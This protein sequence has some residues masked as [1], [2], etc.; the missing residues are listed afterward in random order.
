M[1]DTLAISPVPVV[2]P[3]DDPRQGP[4]M[5]G[6]GIN[7]RYIYA[8]VRANL[9]LVLT[10]IGVS[11]ALSVL[12]SFLQKPV[13]TALTT[14]QINNSSNTRV[15]KKS[16]DDDQG[17]DAS[18]ASDTDLYLRTQVDILK[19]RSLAI[20]VA[21][22]M[23]LGENAAFFKA[24]GVSMPGP[25]STPAMREASA[26]ALL[27]KHIDVQLPHDTRIAQVLFDSRDAAMSAQIVNIYTS[28]YIAANLQRK[29]DSSGY[30]REFLARQLAEVKAKYEAS[31]QALNDYARSAGL[32]T[33]DSLGN[34]SDTSKT[35]GTSVT[36]SS[37]IQLNQSANEAKAR[38]ILAEARWRE[39]STGNGMNATEIVSNASVSQLLG[40]KAVIESAIA[41]ERSRHLDGYPT[42]KSK[43][44]QLTT[45]NQ[46]LQGLI[47]SI[48]NS[49]RAEY[50]VA[51]QS[52]QDLLRQVDALKANR[53]NEQ[54]RNVHYTI[55]AHEQD[56]NKQ[57]Y[58]GLLQRYKEL[59]ASAGV[60][61]SNIS[62]ID[63]AIVPVK[64]SSPNIPRNLLFG[65]IGGILLSAAV[66]AVK[67]QFDDTVRIPE[68]I[69]SKLGLVLLGVIPITQDHDIASQMLDRKSSI[70]EAYNSL[71]GAL[72]YSTPHGLPRTLMVTSAQPSEGKSTSSFA[73]ANVLA[74]M[75]KRVVLID[76]DM[77][78]PSLHRQM[79]SDNTTG[80]SMLLSGQAQVAEAVQLSD[81]PNL[82]YISSGPIP[83]APTEL[84]ASHRMKEMID[85]ASQIFDVVV[86]D[87]PPVL[88]LADAPMVA[89]V[90]DGVIFIAEADRGRHGG[91]KSA[92]N[93]LRSVRA[94]L[95]GGV[96]TKF[97]P[98]KGG[99]RET[100]Y[101]GYS[102][103]N[104]QYGYDSRS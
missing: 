62:V 15:F 90:V 10:L 9:Q 11:I 12:V 84:L 18:N 54:D 80:L 64:P 3:V 49:V 37:L 93:R 6:G 19:S 78:R 20:R 2:A 75:G 51:Q 25:G 46:Q 95:L 56:T 70:S 103:Y 30:A 27:R 85:Q 40:Q 89:G 26:V 35:G 87:C 86:I 91:L 38:R 59:N 67:E 8:S 63:P 4:G 28:E 68:D 101:Y 21:Q 45:I 7:L 22:R 57:L 71:G 43:E 33:T 82:S 41:E 50:Q 39:I 32:I 52:E 16:D 29:F 96:L 92:I 24:E 94:N 100:Y 102:Y 58:D 66:L 36:T 79:G 61:A 42:V 65:V 76:A 74:R 73:L 47:T 53:L 81:Q 104:Y 98:V 44:A 5:G 13:Y 83:P 97:D 23:R 17:D 60:S 88:G 48:R 14:L 55:L 1:T 69:D 99:K 77:R 34:S 72:L 31:E